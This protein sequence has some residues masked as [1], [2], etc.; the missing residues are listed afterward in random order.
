MKREI[1]F[2]GKRVDTN[3][4]IVGGY[5]EWENIKECPRYAIIAP[6]GDYYDVDPGTVGQFTG[7]KDKNG[8]EIYEDDLLKYATLEPA[9]VEYWGGSFGYWLNKGAR[10]QSFMSYAHHNFE[11]NSVKQRSYEHEVIGNIHDN[12]ELLKE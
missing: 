2:R 10:Y 6:N 1:K 4:W 8:K 12:P 9:V 3:Q 7:M 5:T 11:F